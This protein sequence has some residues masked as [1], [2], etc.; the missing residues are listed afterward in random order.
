MPSVE[1]KILKVIIF[2]FFFKYSLFE[3]ESNKEAK[4]KGHDP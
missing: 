4:I 2:K 1:T 3:I